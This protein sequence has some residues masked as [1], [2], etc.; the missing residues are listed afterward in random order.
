MKLGHWVTGSM[1][2]LSHLSRP[3]HRVCQ[4]G[5]R[6][7]GFPGHWVA[8]SQ[9]VTQFCP[10]Y[11][12]YRFETAKT[13]PSTPHYGDQ[14]TSRQSGLR[15]A[16]TADDVGSKQRQFHAGVGVGDSPLP[17]IVSRPPNLAGPKIVARPPN[18]PAT[19]DT[20]SEKLVNLMPPDVR[21]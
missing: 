14:P 19:L 16:A 18:L 3:G 9:N 8:G 7:A 11:L 12:S 1:G 2:H 17:Q 4:L 13:D 10:W 6:V 15:S 21:F 5:L 20:C